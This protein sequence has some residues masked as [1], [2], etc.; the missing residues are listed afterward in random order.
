MSMYIRLR[1]AHFSQI[2]QSGGLLGNVI[3]NLHKKALI[4]IA[5]AWAKDFLAKLATKATFPVT[6]KFK[7]KIRRR[8]YEW[9]Y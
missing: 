5:L 4:E 2:T 7:S 8:K 9:Y 3:S 1:K 6:D